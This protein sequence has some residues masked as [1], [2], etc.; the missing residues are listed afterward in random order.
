MTSNQDKNSSKQDRR[1][2][3]FLQATWCIWFLIA[4]FL[5]LVTTPFI[6]ASF[7]GV[8]PGFVPVAKPRD[9][10][11][12]SMIAGF[13]GPIVILVFFGIGF[14]W[15]VLRCEGKLQKKFPK[16]PWMHRRDWSRRRSEHGLELKAFFLFALA[17]SVSSL[18][19][20]LLLEGIA[21]PQSKLSAEASSETIVVLAVFQGITLVFLVYALW[22]VRNAI[23][24]HA[25][26]CEF[27]S[28]TFRPADKVRCY[29]HWGGVPPSKPIVVALECKSRSVAE[30]PESEVYFESHF[31]SRY[32]T[33]EPTT[34]QAAYDVLP[35]SF[36]LPSKVYETDRDEGVAWELTIQW[37]VSFGLVQTLRFEI[38]VFRCA[39]FESD[40][41]EIADFDRANMIDSNLGIPVDA[42]LETFPQ[43]VS[44]HGGKLKIIDGSN[45]QLILPGLLPKQFLRYSETSLKYEKRSF[46]LGFHESSIPLV[47]VQKFELQQTNK[48][49]SQWFAGTFQV[50]AVMN[51]GKREVVLHNAFSRVLARHICVQLNSRAHGQKQ[52][53]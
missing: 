3:G 12:Q 49:D 5:T 19:W 51:S 44:A 46:L 45:W 17:L 31:Q 32:V 53:S 29:L 47:E 6:L 14:L 28:P 24:F 4:T 9:V 36:Q 33:N 27:V 21:K 8:R 34:P 25:T 48:S 22:L 11:G 13:F 52:R 39:E 23:R 41:T 10:I 50:V 26:F 7:E 16:Q 37:Q 15:S 30:G 18:A 1:G 35:I 38:P 42:R 20:G 2:R 40:S 43:I